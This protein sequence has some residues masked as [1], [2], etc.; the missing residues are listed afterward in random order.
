L[1]AGNA[2]LL[3]DTDRNGA[4][5]KKK[6]AKRFLSRNQWKI[7]KYEIDENYGGRFMKQVRKCRGIL[8]DVRFRI[9]SKER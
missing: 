6:T 3:I 7:A 4:Q 9:F 8:G 5:V 1:N 2:I